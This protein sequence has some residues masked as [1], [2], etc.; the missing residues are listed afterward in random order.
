[1]AAPEADEDEV[2]R[3]AAALE[4]ASEHP[5]AA[6]VVAGARARDLAIPSVSGFGSI[7]GRGVVGRAEGRDVAVGSR[8]LL[9][10]RGVAT[11]AL[12]AIVGPMGAAGSVVVT[13]G[14]SATPGPERGVRRGVDV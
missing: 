3:L 2:L 11:D 4:A 13:I 14:P 10:D 1:M 8:A 9:R 6:A 5:L 7:T 12:D